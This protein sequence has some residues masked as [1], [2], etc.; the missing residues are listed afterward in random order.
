[1]AEIRYNTTKGA[2][3][4]A[5]LCTLFTAVGQLFYKLGSE[6]IT[7]FLSFFN[8]FILIGLFSYFLGSILYILA[9]KKGELTVIL[10]LLALNYVWVALLSIIFLGEIINLLRWLGIFSVI[11]GVIIIG[12]GGGNGN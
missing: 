10:P 2:I 6:K 9:L 8:L 1:V 4:L 5:L 11:I 12:R 3:V 7:D